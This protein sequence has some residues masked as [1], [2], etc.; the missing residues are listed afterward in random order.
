MIEF[1]D[2][3]DWDDGQFRHGCAPDLVFHWSGEPTCLC[4]AP[5]PRH[6]RSFQRWLRRQAK[7]AAADREMDALVG[8][9]SRD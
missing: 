7:R 9:L 3:W 6:A 5:V 4:G 1:G 8:K 2:G